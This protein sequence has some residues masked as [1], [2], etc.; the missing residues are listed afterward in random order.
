M[1]GLGS[2]PEPDADSDA[3][4]GA[5]SA[6]RS[7]PATPRWVK[8]LGIVGLVLLLLIA[9]ILVTG[10]GGPHGPSRHGGLADGARQAAFLAG[11]V[12]V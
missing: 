1:A 12:L 8:V 5:T 2:R 3:R 9:F 4:S 10:L 6:R 7:P 11:E